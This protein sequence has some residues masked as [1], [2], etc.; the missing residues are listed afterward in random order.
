MRTTKRTEP[1]PAEAQELLE[2]A[3][4]V[5]P[6]LNVS[7]AGRYALDPENRNPDTAA[8]VRFRAAI[9]AAEIVAFPQKRK[10]ENE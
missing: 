3:R 7:P 6:I 2:A 10:T 8:I 4:A 1:K 9:V 5:L